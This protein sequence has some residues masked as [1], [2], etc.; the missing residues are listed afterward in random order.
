MGWIRVGKLV[1]QAVFLTYA[2]EKL[3]NKY[4]NL[5]EHVCFSL[6]RLVD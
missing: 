6:L 2:Q 1:R 4:Q 5:A 3:H